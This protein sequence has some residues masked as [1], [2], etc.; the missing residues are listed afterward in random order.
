MRAVKAQL[1]GEHRPL[2]CSSRQLAVN[3]VAILVA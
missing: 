1:S 3:M 2:A